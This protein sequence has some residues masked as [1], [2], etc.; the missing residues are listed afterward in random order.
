MTYKLPLTYCPTQ[1][2]RYKVRHN[3]E[4]S[5]TTLKQ[6]G[7]RKLHVHLLELVKN[8]LSTKNKPPQILIIPK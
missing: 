6:T 4:V 8:W 2:F 7:L 3:I 1:L 5:H